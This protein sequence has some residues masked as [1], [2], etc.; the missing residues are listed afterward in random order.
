[1]GAWVGGR[2]ADNFIKGFNHRPPL[3]AIVRRALKYHIDEHKNYIQ[4]IM[5]KWQ[6]IYRMAHVATGSSEL[7]EVVLHEA[8]LDAYIHMDEGTMR[9][10]MRK[11]ISDAA[12]SQ[13]KAAKKAG[14][15]ELDW[16]GFIHKPE[17]LSEQ[18]APLWECLAEQTPEAQR[19]VML[20][21]ALRWSPR[22]IADVMDMHTGAVKELYQRVVAQLQR[23]G[24]P[25][26]NVAHNMNISPFDRAMNRIVRLELSR[27][28][29]D[30]PDVAAVM[31]A[32][33][34]DACAVHRPNFTARKLTGGVLRMA[35]ALVAALIFYMG[36]I[37]AQDPYDQATHIASGRTAPDA[38]AAPVL[39][40]PA[41]GKY[42]MIDAGRQMDIRDLNQLRY[43]F[44]LPVA[45]LGA[46]G[47]SVSGACIR[48]ERGMGGNT[49]RAAVLEYVDSDGRKV[50]LRSM[51]PG[52]E[53]CERLEDEMS[54]VGRSA[55]MAAHEAVQLKS[56]TISR[57]YTMV[58]QAVYCIEGELPLEELSELAAQVVTG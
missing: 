15:L 2:R 45:W 55:T 9:E 53:A 28:G 8:L 30:L 40:L 57:V 4:K 38:T 25:S 27:S 22:Q 43:Y 52:D 26:T 42:E 46:E 49:T 47:W 14:N 41:L 13:L 33:E 20:R 39:T 51:L 21:Y 18:D 31:Q 23:R 48:D 11:A 50:M 1:M 12:M 54:Y 58:G 29:A 5:N 24:G 56:S 16:E 7:A 44:S 19:I 36:A 35:V 32:F 6:S 10:N 17:A 37:M 3:A 34:Q